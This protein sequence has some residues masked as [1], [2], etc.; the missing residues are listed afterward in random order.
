MTRPASACVALLL[1]CA[2]CGED[3]SPRD[4]DPA[5]GSPLDA[6]TSSP[7]DDAQSPQAM[8]SGTSVSSQDAAAS[9]SPEAGS[10]AGDAGGSKPEKDASVRPALVLEVP[11]STV[12]CGGKPCDTLANV[13]C[14]SWS[15]GTGFGATQSCVTRDQC[16]KMFSRSGEQ[17]RA[18]PHEC[19]GKEDCSGGQVCCLY[20]PGQPLCEFADLAMCIT[21]LFGPGGAGICVDDDKCKLG[22]TQFVAEGVPLGILACNDNADCADRAGTSCQAEESNSISTGKGVNARSHIKVCR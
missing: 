22:S 2:A 15:K 18:I 11:T 16:Q 5:P 19:D 4:Q 14:E 3:G 9:S 7:V 21:K 8:D 12:P 17:N 6:T 1:A 20:A 10:G 13:C